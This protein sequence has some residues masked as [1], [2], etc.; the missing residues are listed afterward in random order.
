MCFGS[1]GSSAA[2]PAA[3]PTPTANPLLPQADP[4]TEVWNNRR[5]QQN[6]LS[7]V[8]AT[9]STMVPAPDATND[10]SPTTALKK[11]MGA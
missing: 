7:G 1:G 8:G 9:G 3:T 2:A 4:T 6:Q 5:R 10:N 11:L